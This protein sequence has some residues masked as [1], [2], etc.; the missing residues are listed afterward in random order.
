[1]GALFGVLGAL[2][3]EIDGVDV[4]PHAPKERALLTLLIMNR[5]RVEA[6]DTL[7][8]E[9]WPQL[10]APQARRVL[11]VRM[12]EVRKRLGVA[13]PRA[14]RLVEFVAP[15]YRL[16]VA[17]EDVDEQRFF[18]LVAQAQRQRQAGDHGSAAG[19]LRAALALWRGEP[20]ADVQGSVR[21]EMEAARLAEARLS[22]LEECIDAE[23]AG[24]R[25]D[26]L[27]AE[28]RPLVAAH[29]ER[30][31][32]W[33]QLMVCLYRQGRQAE[34]LATYGELRHWLAEELGLTPSRELRQL[35]HDILVHAP[36]LA[37]PATPPDALP[38]PRLSNVPSGPERMPFVGRQ[39]QMD[40]LRRWW[41]STESRGG[42]ALLIGEAGVG[43]TR[44][45][46]RFARQVEDDGFLVLSGR[47]EAGASAYEPV[48]GALRQF[49]VT[50]HDDELDAL[51]ETSL[52]AAS[53]LLP[54]VA[55]RRPSIAARAAAWE[56]VD[57]S[58]LLG[59]V[60]ACLAGPGRPPVLVVLD[61]LQ[62]ADRP[63]LLLLS[64]LL[65]NDTRARVLGTVR[66]HSGDR[67]GL[68]GDFLADL[69]RA[70]RPV[71]R[72]PISGLTSDDVATIMAG[73]AGLAGEELSSAGRR[74]AGELHRRTDG[75]PFFLRETLRQLDD[76]GSNVTAG[77]RW[78]SVS[79]ADLAVPEGVTAVVGQRLAHL[80]P[81][82]RDVLRAAAVVGIEFDVD[83]VTGVLGGDDRQ[84]VGAVEEAMAAG[85]V[86]AEPAEFDRYDFVHALVR[87]VVLNELSVSRRARLEW[88]AG[89]A[90]Q[91]LRA[92]ELDWRSGEVA[93][94]FF[95]GAPAGD[96]RTAVEWAL[97][98][99]THA[100][101]VFAYEDAVRYDEMALRALER[102]R[103]PTDEERVDVLIALGGAC[104]R[105]GASERWR[106]A[107]LEAVAL[108]RRAGD[109]ERRA[110]AAISLLG[111]LGPWP[112]DTT[113]EAL[114]EAVDALRTAEPTPA[115]RA[116]LSEV[117]ARLGG[118]LIHDVEGR[119][120]DLTNEAVALARGERDR[121]RLVLA[122][123]YST[124]TY[125]L[126]REEHLGRVREAALLADGIDDLEIAL[127][128]NTSLM[129]G[130]LTWADRDDF[131]RGLANYSCLA[132]ATKAAVPLLLSAVNAAGMAALD[133]GYEH[134][135]RQLDDAFE[136]ATP[137]GDPYLPGL[138]RT[139]QLPVDRELG[140]LASRLAMLARVGER[141][142]S[143]RAVGPFLTRVLCEA[144]EVDE[145][146]IR[147]RKVIDEAGHV[148]QGPSRRACLALVAESAE[149]L[150]DTEA[151]AFLHGRL[152]N[153]RRFGECIAMGANAWFGALSR[154]LGL[155]ARMLGRADEAVGHQEDALAVHRRMRAPGWEARSR[156][157]LA[158]ALL[159]RRR[160]G[161]VAYA[162]DLLESA[163]RAAADL[164]MPKLIEEV[165]VVTPAGR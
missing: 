154:Y 22:A 87:D 2:E 6:A 76:V 35:E 42:M 45:A 68:L 21:L 152:L 96:A 77:D 18:A 142:S 106:R 54:E 98:A 33:A 133:G 82:T 55:E 151:A 46:T 158:R 103:D 119:A 80:A 141:R 60:A 92:A 16:I 112:D 25:Y 63:A 95:A 72:L 3:V 12:A 116:L 70:D 40:E 14:A 32:F 124:H 139:G 64:R 69:R 81:A 111:T 20:L 110:R 59:A 23:L 75:N 66:T 8:E 88:A 90:L 89:T 41:E 30:E 162:I 85:F 52:A 113:L 37:G 109:P 38:H 39:A 53:R 4:T 130:G 107:C 137:L 93:Q 105:A 144:G 161:D 17:P 136:R 11:Q 29:P 101:E 19:T 67:D 121:R 65:E 91:Q 56:D 140:L 99:A 146:A 26:A 164:G 78:A 104:N 147:L 43:K 108:A 57:R 117:L 157:D 84:V 5:G 94:H 159:C 132:A 48:L 118:F 50:A 86:H 135:R 28:L 13:G 120:A 160:A 129:V 115:R 138:I 126:E 15:G 102:A 163:G 143:H 79:L 148:F 71:R 44:L 73:L 62:W 58:W 74:L 10:P 61:D 49:I 165:R 97:R 153:E 145:A 125:T 47:T 123:T 131:D 9:L 150:G 1:M 127:A 134:A 122:L 51:S 36:S 34:A 114:Q 100:E 7:I 128:A 27:V 83:V 156:Y 155:L 24:G 31:R 149:L